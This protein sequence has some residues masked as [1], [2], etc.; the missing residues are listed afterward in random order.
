VKTAPPASLRVS[1]KR[2]G[3]TSLTGAVA[4]NRPGDV[5]LTATAAGKVIARGTVAGGGK[6]AYEL[7]L[8]RRIPKHAHVK[9]TARVTAGGRTYTRSVRRLARPTEGGA[10]R[11]PCR[12]PPR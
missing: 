6:R 3:K 9:L 1:L 8:R 10:A 11:P 12:R 7:R 2:P 4:F 5:A